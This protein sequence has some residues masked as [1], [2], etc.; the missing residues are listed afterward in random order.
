MDCMDQWKD[1]CID[2]TKGSIHLHGGRGLGKDSSFASR[3]DGWVACQSKGATKK[4]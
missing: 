2:L 1:G 3:M 4:T